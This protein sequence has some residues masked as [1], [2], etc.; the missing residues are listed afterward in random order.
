MAFLRISLNFYCDYLVVRFRHSV[1]LY[2]IRGNTIFDN[3]SICVFL[4]CK[5]LSPK[6]VTTFPENPTN[7]FSHVNEDTG[8][9]EDE[10]RGR[11]FH[12]AVRNQQ[13]RKIHKHEKC[14]VCFRRKKNNFHAYYQ[15]RASITQ[16]N[17]S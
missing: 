3:D 6:H 5:D 10:M 12:F 9:N 14:E 17:H 13:R 1:L 7:I 15:Y 8:V 2:N 16:M 4:S 11:N